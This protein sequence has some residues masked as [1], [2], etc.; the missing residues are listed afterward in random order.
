VSAGKKGQNI[1][2]SNFNY[3]V[4]NNMRLKKGGQ[5]NLRIIAP[6]ELCSFVG[7]QIANAIERQLENG[8][9]RIEGYEDPRGFRVYIS[10]SNPF[11]Q[12]G[13]RGRT[14][15]AKIYNREELEKIAK[16]YSLFLDDNN[17]EKREI[18]IMMKKSGVAVSIIKEVINEVLP[19]KWVK[20]GKRGIF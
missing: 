11:I 5:I 7:R 1:N 4:R 2:L 3:K 19:V 17:G 16:N 12:H 10:V 14:T 18:Q 13:P 20:G 15:T 8:T 9:L 6:K